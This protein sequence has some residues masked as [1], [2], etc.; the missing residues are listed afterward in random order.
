MFGNAS[1][2]DRSFIVLL[3]THT[4]VGVGNKE[5]EATISMISLRA[6]LFFLGFSETCASK[7]MTYHQKGHDY[8]ER[9]P[10]QTKDGS[11]AH[12]LVFFYITV[13]P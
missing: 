13:I 10:A 6:P 1:A 7:R 4:A 3:T 12:L 9:C 11:N 2:Y 8:F 5:M